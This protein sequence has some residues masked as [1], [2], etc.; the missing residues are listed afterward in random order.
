MRQYAI[1]FVETDDKIYN[2]EIFDFLFWKIV[3]ELL[4]WNLQYYFSTNAQKL[5][6]K[7][8]ENN[9]KTRCLPLFSTRVVL[10]F[11][12]FYEKFITFY[13]VF[14]NDTIATY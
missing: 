14:R 2:P 9:D 1:K 13:H 7:L 3:G 8:S 6:E 11:Q 10:S 4:F 12:S 5:K